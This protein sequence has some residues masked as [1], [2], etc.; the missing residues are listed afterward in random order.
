MHIL[1]LID[2]DTLKTVKEISNQ[3]INC[4]G[5][6]EKSHIIDRSESQQQQQTKDVNP[7][8]D[9]RSFKGISQSP[10]QSNRKRRTTVN[11]CTG[12]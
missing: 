2:V 8:L 5:V 3:Y 11:P 7:Q 1:H 6:C 12:I 10:R 4:S 9:I